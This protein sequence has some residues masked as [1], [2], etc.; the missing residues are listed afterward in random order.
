MVGQ[1]VGAI[2]A[3]VFQ[4]IGSFLVDFVTGLISASGKFKNT[5]LLALVVGLVVVVVMFR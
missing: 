2:I 3:Q 1:G 5:H 4:T